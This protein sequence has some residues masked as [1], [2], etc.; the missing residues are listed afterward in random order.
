M[1]RL[2]WR[3]R[4]QDSSRTFAEVRYVCRMS[5]HVAPTGFMHGS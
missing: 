2:T 5:T 4:T 3:T 1:E